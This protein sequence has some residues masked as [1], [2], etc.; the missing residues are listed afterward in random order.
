MLL[1]YLI[2]ITIT[3]VTALFPSYVFLFRVLICNKNKEADYKSDLLIFILL[4]G[5]LVLY[6][7]E[8]VRLLHKFHLLL[9]YSLFEVK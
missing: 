8:L 1:L 9:Y 7:P 4:F 6:L 2:N 5:L 3:S